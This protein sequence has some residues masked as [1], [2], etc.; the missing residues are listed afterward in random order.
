MFCYITMK[1]IIFAKWYYRDCY[2]NDWR[3]THITVCISPQTG[4]SLEPIV[5]PYEA[6]QIQL[7]QEI[8]SFVS[9]ISM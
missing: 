1:N 8:A 5:E 6:Q 3:T 7:Y 9:S 2:S 4:W